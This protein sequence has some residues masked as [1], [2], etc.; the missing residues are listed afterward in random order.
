MLLI[1]SSL[2]ASTSYL[3]LGREKLVQRVRGHAAETHG[4]IVEHLRLGS[5]GRDDGGLVETAADA[6]SENIVNVDIANLGAWTTHHT[7]F[8]NLNKILIEMRKR[9]IRGFQFKVIT[10]NQL[11]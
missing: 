5:K 2:K 10:K 9:K 4:R 8:G 6:R 1:S 11:A 7:M 3:R